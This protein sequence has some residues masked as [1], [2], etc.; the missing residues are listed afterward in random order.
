MKVVV[1]VV[2]DPVATATPLINRAFQA[3]TPRI[4]VEGK[5]RVPGS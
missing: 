2:E 5:E 4:V 1:V 3:V